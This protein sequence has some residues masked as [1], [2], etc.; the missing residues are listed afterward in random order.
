MKAAPQIL[1]LGQTRSATTK[2]ASDCPVKQ[3][4][5]ACFAIEEQI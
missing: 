5:P 2:L 4:L 3:P 1:Q